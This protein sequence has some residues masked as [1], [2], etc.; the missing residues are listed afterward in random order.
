VSHR[1]QVGRPA[2]RATRVRCPSL[3]VVVRQSF[4][5]AVIL[6]LALGCS[7]PVPPPTE[8]TGPADSGPDGGTD[9]GPAVPVSTAHCTYEAIPAT[10]H[11]GGTV[12]DAP[13]YAG[14]GES[15]LH[16]PIGVTLGAY[17]SRAEGAGSDGFIDQRRTEIAGAFAASIGIE[18]WPRARALAISTG[19][20][21]APGAMDACGDT[22]LLLKADLAIG[23]QGLTQELEHRLG[24]DFA[25]RV[26]VATSHS[27]SSFANYTAHTGMQVAF[28]PFRRSVFDHIVDDLEA[29]A[30]HALMTRAPARVGFAHDGA[31]DPENRVNRDR[32]TENDMLAG[33]PRDDH[34][35]FVLRVDTYDPAM[36]TNPAVPLALVPVFGMH[37]TIHDGDNVYASTDAPGGVERVL[38]EQFDRPVLVMH[39]QGAGGDVSPVGLESGTQCPAGSVLCHDFMREETVGWNAL[40]AVIAAYDAAGTTMLDHAPMEMVSRSIDRG[41]DWTHFTV[42][43]GALSYTPWD[44]YTPADRMVV[45]A[46]G[47]LISPIDEFNAPYGA[48]LCG[49]AD[50]P[51]VPTAQLPGTRHLTE[52]PYG[53]CNRIEAIQHLLSQVLTIDLGAH[54]PLCDT[55]RTTVSAIRIGDWYMSTLPGE[56]LT[57]SAD[58][59]RSLVTTV[60]ADHH[61]VVGYAQDNIGYILMPEDWILGGYE[62]TITFWGPLDGESLLEQSAALFPLLATPERE[63]AAMGLTHVQ[64]PS[65]AE[66]TIVH[67]DPSPMA[68]TI[69]AA[70][71]AYVTSRLLPASPPSVQPPA[72][73]RR[74]ESAF[75]TWIGA[76]PLDGTPLVTIERRQSDGSFLPL[77]RHSGRIVG[78]GD[79]LLSWTPDPLNHDEMLTP[80]THYYTVEWQAVPALGQVGFEGTDTRAGLPLG[81]Y[82]ITATL[83]GVSSYTVHSSEFAVVAGA[84]E[85]TRTGG[86][87]TMVTFTAGYHAPGGYRMLDEQIGANRFVPIRGGTVDVGVTTS[88]GTTPHT[89]VAIDTN[90]TVTIDAGA[91]AIS[92]TV[93]DVYGNTGTLTL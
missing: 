30:R 24:P 45:D 3:E 57:L 22:V 15:V 35:L 26:V 76:D 19:C 25:G 58:H 86:T 82:R 67:R 78:D 46:T 81:T 47:A 54:A 50:A 84:L 92:L 62:P 53:S 59:L 32:R 93:T 14:V 2:A 10:A 79:F 28:G 17:A 90:G 80:R 31:F 34:D 49:G 7:D 48:A 36:P 21:G 1:K 87:G 55:T 71:P 23:Y 11:S 37:G 44:G 38:E 39:L 73:I 65:P 51:F 60:P 63:N 77:A 4:Y 88:S 42:R 27:H 52:W 12:A 74:F 89:G 70:L 83:T 18:T 75:F 5:A 20:T 29:V 85:L 64:T 33:G 6:A 40:D 69:P 91:G 13:F 9:G 66:D 41:P 56:P 43:H 16:V 72:M 61:I 8:D 68:G